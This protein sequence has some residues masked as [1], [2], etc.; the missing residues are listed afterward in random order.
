MSAKKK[1][2]TK[3]KKE[4]KAKDD[5]KKEE[6][7]PEIKVDREA[8][9]RKMFSKTEE[10]VEKAQ[11]KKIGASRLAK[12]K[13]FG[14]VINSQAGEGTVKVSKA[15]SKVLRMS[16]GI[17]E[18]DLAMGG[19]WAFNGKMG[20]IWGLQSQ[21][22]SEICYRTIAEVQKHCAYCVQLLD[23]CVCGAKEP[24][25]TN[26]IDIENSWED[27][28]AIS[29]G[30]DPDLVSF[31]QPD[32]LEDTVDYITESINQRLYSLHIL[33]SIA[34]STPEK[35]LEE[36][37][38]KWQQGLSARIQNKGWR[39]WTNALNKSAKDGFPQLLIV[40]NQQREKIGVMFGDPST[41]PGGK[42][43]EFMPSIIIK[44]QSP[45]YKKYDSPITGA[46]ETYAVDLKGV[47]EKNKTAPAKAKYSFSMFTRDY[48]GQV[49]GFVD[50]KS[51]L[52][53]CIEKCNW[54]IKH[55]P[56][57][58]ALKDPLNEILNITPEG[59]NEET[60]EITG[61]VGCKEDKEVGPVFKTK[62]AMLDAIIYGSRYVQM[63]KMIVTAVTS[64]N[65][66]IEMERVEKTEEE[67]ALENQ[68]KAING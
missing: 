49:K 26:M 33:D 64:G 30:I 23:E 43:Q 61:D 59:I 15:H 53:K 28:W 21:G 60:G 35:E 4:T 57:K 34:M 19:G 45:E 63:R 1:D 5:K 37:Q 3:E 17:L 10:E 44:T 46:E 6:V 62:G 12:L 54:L 40:I 50:E 42:S 25:L 68:Q 41:K 9:I 51:F 11:A 38:S 39:A 48:N 31:A 36:G 65:V 67:I 52:L 56:T 13:K 29:K 27:D 55:S 7:V 47:I 22:K 8:I 16:T 58:W 20:L 24:M 2:E 14:E 66:Q 32:A 18:L